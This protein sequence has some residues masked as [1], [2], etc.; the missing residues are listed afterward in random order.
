MLFIQLTAVHASFLPC[1]LGLIPALLPHQPQLYG[2]ARLEDWPD[3]IRLVTG[4]DAASTRWYPIGNRLPAAKK[5]NTHASPETFY[6]DVWKELQ[7]PCSA[8][9]SS[10]KPTSTQLLL[11]GPNSHAN[12]VINLT[13]NTLLK[14]ECHFL[15][16][17]SWRFQFCWLIAMKN[18]VSLLQKETSTCATDV[19][20]ILQFS[21]T[22][23]RIDEKPILQRS[24]VALLNYLGQMTGLASSFLWCPSIGSLCLK[25]GNSEQRTESFDNHESTHSVQDD[26]QCIN[27]LNY[28]TTSYKPPVTTR[29]HCSTNLSTC[30][31]LPK[32]P[33]SV[34]LKLTQSHCTSWEWL[35]ISGSPRHPI[36]INVILPEL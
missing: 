30:N 20:H 7:S 35:F 1:G 18:A 26:L 4:S 9:I 28:S 10:E 12:Q 36:S 34:H 31:C 14:H 27:L 2:R 24:E 29:T 13:I 5:L 21:N 32:N 22:F 15:Q 17:N 3:D 11:A 25:Q 8:A 33:T 16:I 23:H 19:A 6:T